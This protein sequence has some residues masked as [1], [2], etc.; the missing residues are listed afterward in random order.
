MMDDAKF[1]TRHS[2]MPVPAKAGSG[3]LADTGIAALGGMPVPAKAG[4]GIQR[5]IRICD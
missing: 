2:R 1:V 4:A 3:N 5:C